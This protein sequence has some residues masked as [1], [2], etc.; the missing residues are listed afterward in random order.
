MS[1]LQEKASRRFTI[2]VRVQ[3]SKTLKLFTGIHSF[4]KM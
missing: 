4:I 2:Q 1:C 3:V